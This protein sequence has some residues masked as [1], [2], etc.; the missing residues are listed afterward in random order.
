MFLFVQEKMGNSAICSAQ[1]CTN[2]NFIFAVVNKPF[3]LY[4][5]SSKAMSRKLKK[6][7]HKTFSVMFL[8]NSGGRHGFNCLLML[9][10]F[11]LKEVSPSMYSLHIWKRI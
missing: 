8:C 5:Y 4:I 9:L 10:I 6:A 3:V 7:I 2:A 1:Y 11:K